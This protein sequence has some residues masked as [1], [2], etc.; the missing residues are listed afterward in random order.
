[1]ISFPRKKTAPK[2]LINQNEAQGQRGQKGF[3]LKS[4]EPK[5]P[6]VQRNSYGET[7]R[8]WNKSFILEKQKHSLRIFCDKWYEDVL[9]MFVCFHYLSYTILQCE[10]VVLCCIIHSSFIVKLHIR[11]PT[12]TAYCHTDTH[13]FKSSW[14]MVVTPYYAALCLAA[15]IV[16]D[17]LLCRL[18]SKITSVPFGKAPA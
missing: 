11:L 15:F 3:D 17:W 10:Y 1:M 5:K 4:W 8:H 16:F 14:S 18:L 13:C 9:L 2:S 12:S 6:V 7:T